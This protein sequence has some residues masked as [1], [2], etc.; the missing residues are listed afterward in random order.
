MSCLF[1]RWNE[2]KTK[3]RDKIDIVGLS[4]PSWWQQRQDKPNRQNIYGPTG[5]IKDKARVGDKIDVLWLPNP[6]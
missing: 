3:A 2:R 1:S 4:F 6:L 5:G